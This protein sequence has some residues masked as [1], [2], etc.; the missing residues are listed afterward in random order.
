MKSYCLNELYSKN[1]DVA[2]AEAKSEYKSL[3]KVLIIK[4]LVLTMQVI[5]VVLFIIHGILYSI[6]IVDRLFCV[7]LFTTL[8]YNIFFIKTE[9]II[10]GWHCKAKLRV[11][12]YEEIIPY[13]KFRKNFI[14]DKKLMNNQITQDEWKVSKRNEV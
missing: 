7:F 13:E 9:A 1:V 10:G 11:K 3:R 8:F 12:D 4:D 2:Y 6:S 5:G 14:L